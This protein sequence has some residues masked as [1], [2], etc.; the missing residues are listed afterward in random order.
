MIMMTSVENTLTPII[1]LHS[2]NIVIFDYRTTKFAVQVVLRL[3]TVTKLA[4][5]FSK[6][7]MKREDGVEEGIIGGLMPRTDRQSCF[8]GATRR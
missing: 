7:G 4:G 5:E 3:E 8:R 2:P 1:K 6:K